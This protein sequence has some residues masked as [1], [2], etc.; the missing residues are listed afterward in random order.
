MKRRTLWGIAL[1]LIAVCCAVLLLCGRTLTVRVNVQTPNPDALTVRLDQDREIVRLTDQHVEEGQLC[2]TFEAVS[3]GKAYF[4]VYDGGDGVFLDSLYV[5]PFGLLTVNSCFGRMNGGWAIQATTAA[6]LALLLWHMILLYRRGMRE[7]L[8]QYKNIRNLAWIIFFG[9]MLL[10]QLPLLLT[11][12][13]LDSTVSQALS[14]GAGMSLFAFPIAFV[15]SI[16][17]SISN[18]QLMRRE[19]RNW[20]NMLGFLLGLLLCFGTLF[21]NLLSEYLQRSSSAIIDVHNMGGWAY[22]AEAFS[23]SAVLTIVS[24]LECI[25][26]ATIVLSLRAAKHVPA[27]DKD[28]MLILGC[29]IRKD[30]T[31]TPLLRGRADRALV[32]AAMQRDA[33]GKALTFV[34]SGGQGADEVVS[35]AEAI[36]NY[37]LQQGVPEG[38]I[39]PEDQSANTFENLRNAAALIRT[40]AGD[41]AKIA[42]AT[43]NYHVFRAGVL[44]WQQGIA[45]EGIGSPTRSYFWINAFVREFIATVYAE[46]KNHLKILAVM[47]LLVVAMVALMYIS[48]NS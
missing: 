34:P 44:A 10:G 36:R 35:E 3:R 19:G 41:G 9:M 16:L 30:G 29:Q 33:A 20:R 7:S 48:N 12:E 39:L 13:S 25:L 28:Y 15:L 11:N 5:H 23:R 26:A 46:R 43:T 47:L 31:V 8:Y 42:F 22:Y 4:E 27:F 37:L 45:A 17:V 18:V 24:Y 21:P 6:L 2:L 1:G 38:Q 32:F 40:R 14:A